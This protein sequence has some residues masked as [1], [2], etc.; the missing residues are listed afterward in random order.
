[1][2]TFRIKG[3]IK[4]SAAILFLTVLA[5]CVATL[6]PGGH[7]HAAA[8]ATTPEAPPVV[9]ITAP[10]NN[11]SYSWNSLV[12]YSVVVTYNGKSTQYQEIPSNEVLLKTTWVAD[13]TKVS[14]DRGS[15]ATP[16]GLLDIV[17]SNCLGCHQ[18]R[19]KAMGP[20]FAA[21]AKR[22]PD[23]PASA[24]S[25][26]RYIHD[27]STGIFGQGS[28]PPHPELTDDQLQAIVHWIEKEADDSNVNYYAGTEGA[29]RME[30]PAKPGPKA[31]LIVTASYTAP[32]AKASRGE[33]TVILRGK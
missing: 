32:A 7:V 31:G 12:N 22:F 17:R 13:A 28:M 24:E 18:F 33:A 26:A 8:Q 27:G 10:A 11:S 23:D 9:R 30:A 20:S 6:S 25:L 21:V 3:R 15:A 16:A 19:A 5:V 4:G 29:L 14:A 1:M 2:M